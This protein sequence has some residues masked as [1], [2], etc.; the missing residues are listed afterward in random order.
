M[1]LTHTAPYAFDESRIQWAPIEVP[2]CGVLADFEFAPLAGSM[3]LKV[4]DFLVRR[5]FRQLRHERADCQ[6]ELSRRDRHGHLL[7]ACC[8]PGE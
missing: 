1:S 7:Y 6:R 5:G 3:E 2:G 4:V 8:L